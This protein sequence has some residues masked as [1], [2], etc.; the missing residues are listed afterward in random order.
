MSVLTRADFFKP[1]T[2]R[3]RMV[4]LPLGGKVRIQSLTAG[5]TRAL[6]QSLLNSKGELIKA[7]GD[8]LQ[9]ILICACLVDE[10]GNRIFSDADA[11]SGDWDNFDSA[12]AAVVYQ[13]CKA[14][15]GFGADADFAAIEDAIKNSES[16]QES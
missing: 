1:A 12:A 13:S 8:R 16:T 4:S 5:E 6:R 2:R 14:W 7:R 11:M 3:Y 15:T 10:S 9:E